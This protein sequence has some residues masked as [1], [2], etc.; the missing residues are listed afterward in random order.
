MPNM[1]PYPRIMKTVFDGTSQDAAINSMVI[2][3]VIEEIVQP[4]CTDGGFSSGRTWSI[5]IKDQHSDE[6]SPHYILHFGEGEGC[7]QITDDSCAEVNVNYCDTIS[8]PDGTILQKPGVFIVKAGGEFGLV[9]K[10]FAARN[11]AEIYAGA[12]KSNLPSYAIVMDVN[13]FI[14][15][16][17]LTQPPLEA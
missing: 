7:D 11:A 15:Y 3:R 10:E 8:E 12:L 4:E 9:T 5:C 14:P 2:S 17:R 6:S 1:Y 13:A 16:F